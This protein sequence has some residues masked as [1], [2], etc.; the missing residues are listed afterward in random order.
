MKIGN[1]QVTN[2][3]SF[4]EA[5]GKTVGKF[6]NR[7]VEVFQPEKKRVKDFQSFL[8]KTDDAW[9]PKTVKRKTKPPSKTL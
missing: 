5:M 9:A 6:M 3:K 7:L 1:T 2:V 4:F 8:V